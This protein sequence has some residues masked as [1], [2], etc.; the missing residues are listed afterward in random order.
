M[1]K[2]GQKKDFF[3]CQ[4]VFSGAAAAVCYNYNPS[5]SLSLSDG[6]LKGIKYSKQNI[7]CLVHLTVFKSVGGR[8][9]FR[10]TKATMFLN[11]CAAAFAFSLSHSLTLNLV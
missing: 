7:R 9:I 5:L 2:K 6:A 8:E 11:Y 3:F 10:H 4:R 1:T